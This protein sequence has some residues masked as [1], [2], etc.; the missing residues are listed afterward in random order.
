VIYV[1]DKKPSQLMPFDAVKGKIIAMLR[2]KRFAERM[3][4]ETDALKKSAKIEME[5]A[6]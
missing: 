2:Q 3:K 4:Q 6:K 1:E 5:G